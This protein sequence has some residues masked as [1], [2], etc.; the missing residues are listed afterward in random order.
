MMTSIARVLATSL[1][2][3]LLPVA[4]I[5]QGNLSTQGYGYP[6]GQLSTRALATGG[7]LGELDATTPLNPGAVGLLVNRTVLFQIEPEFRTLTSAGVSEHTTTARYPVVYAGVPFGERWVTSV[8]SSTL[9]DR[10]W[11]TSTSRFAP[12]GVDS[13]FTTFKESSNGAIN[14]VRVAEAWSNRKWFYVGAGIHGITGR[15]VVTT[16]RQF[17]D[18]SQFSSF[19]ASRTISYSGTAVSIGAELIGGDKGAIGVDFRKG[20]RMRARIND[21]TLAQGNV[22]DHFGVS[23]SFTGIQGSTLAVRAAHDSWSSMNSLLET[24]GQQGHDSWDLSGGAE[25][26]GPRYANQIILIRGGFRDRR[27]PFDAA[28]KPVTER[29]LSLGSGLGF[30]GGRVQIDITGVRQ[31]RTSDVPSVQERAWTLSL[32]LTARP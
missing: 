9:L 30:S 20:G 4:L 1:S 25:V 24:P 12:V 7:A 15:N 13:E 6:Q 2:G 16:G 17:A 22:P 10:S 8:S 32:S 18:T 26:A 14:D 28:S 29:S 31:W 11:A 21:S 3:A 19:S 23:L 27:L 5:A